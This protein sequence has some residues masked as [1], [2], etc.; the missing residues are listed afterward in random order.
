MEKVAIGS[1]AAGLLVA[2]TAELAANPLGLPIGSQ[3]WPLRSMLK[4]FPAFAKMLSGIGVARL[5]LCSPIGYGAEFSSLANGKE[6]RKI[7]ADH[8]LKA[9]SSHFTMDELR[10]SQEQSIEWAKEIGITQMIT[11]SLGDGNGGATRRST[12]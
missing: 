3:V 7:L 6:V 11:A 10:H 5:E 2:S 12:R 1:G 8:G 9:E 4:D